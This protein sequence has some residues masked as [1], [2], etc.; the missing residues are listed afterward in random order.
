VLL[1]L[2]RLLDEAGSFAEA[3]HRASRQEITAQHVL[4]WPAEGRLRLFVPAALLG[5]HARRGD[6]VASMRRLF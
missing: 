5:P 3:V 6:D 2:R 1:F 4:A